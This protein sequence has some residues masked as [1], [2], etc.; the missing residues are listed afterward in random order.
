M[1]DQPHYPYRDGDHVGAAT[2][3]ICSDERHAAKVAA[4]QADLDRYEEVLGDLNETLVDRAQQA[5]RAEAAITR[6]RDAATILGDDAKAAR[7]AGHEQAAYALEGAAL[8]IRTALDEPVPAATEPHTGLVVQ[9]YRN[10]R[11][12]NVWVFRC[13]GTDSCDGWLSLDHRSEQSAVRARDRHVAE[14]HAEQP[15]PATITDPE[16]L[17]Q[18]YTAIISALHDNRPDHIATELLRV[19]DRHLAQLR[20]RLQL[21]DQAH[22]QEQQYA[23]RLAGLARD[24]LYTGQITGD[25]IARWREQLDQ[26]TDQQPA[27]NGPTV[28][29]CAEADRRWPLEKHGE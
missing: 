25:R 24:I 15:E 19:R 3:L 28:R 11:G 1:S 26:L 4:L 14:E 22:R 21:A 17:R 18:Q 9:P 2:P 5:A 12:E 16:Y 29:E 7:Q 6:V 13:W 20:Q 10:D 27:H 8:R 23:D